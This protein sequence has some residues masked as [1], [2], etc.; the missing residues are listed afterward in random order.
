MNREELNIRTCVNSLSEN[1]SKDNVWAFALFLKVKSLFKNGVIYNYTPNKLRTLTGF[2]DYQVRKYTSLA[3]KEGLLSIHGSNLHCLSFKNL[4]AKTPEE[5]FCKIIQIKKSDS[6]KDIESKI[7]F[8]FLQIRSFDRYNFY[9]TKK[10]DLN[11]MNDFSVDVTPEERSRICKRFLRFQSEQRL[12]KSNVLEKIENLTSYKIGYRLLSEYMGVSV[13]KVKPLLKYFEKIGY[14][15]FARSFPQRIKSNN[16]ET[17]EPERESINPV[18][19]YTDKHGDTYSIE[20]TNI[21]Y[22]N[23]GLELFWDTKIRTKKVS[24]KRMTKRNA[25]AV[26]KFQIDILNTPDSIKRFTEVHNKYAGRAEACV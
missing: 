5:K 24:K 7:R 12:K 4:R 19:L 21:E 15:K 26:H 1:L 9:Y 8:T 18:Y 3:I 17:S 20:G 6:L 14:I 22:A 2:S 13:A 16:T 11:D 23:L 10:R 25:T